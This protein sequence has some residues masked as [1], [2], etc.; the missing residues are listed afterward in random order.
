[1]AVR[2]IAEYRLGQDR[3]SGLVVFKLRNSD[4]TIT[5]WVG[6]GNWIPVPFAQFASLVGMLTTGSAS[7]DD[8]RGVF[9]LSSREVRTMGILEEISV[10]ERTLHKKIFGT[11]PSKVS[12]KAIPKKKK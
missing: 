3:A 1:M 9:L 10:K 4:G 2:K 6:G 12:S 8:S 7:Y 11:V 5:D